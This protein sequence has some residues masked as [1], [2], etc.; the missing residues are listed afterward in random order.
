MEEDFGALLS[1]RRNVTK[2]NPIKFLTLPINGEP[3]TT[4]NNVAIQQDWCAGHK[5]KDVLNR[6]G[7]F[8]KM[9][10]Y[11]QSRRPVYL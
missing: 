9:E 11:P 6:H 4:K 5:I 1:C 10:E 8:K 2:A 7:E 3:Y